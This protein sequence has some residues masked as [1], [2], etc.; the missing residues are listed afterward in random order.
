MRVGVLYR[1]FDS[2]RHLCLVPTEARRW[3]ALGL[4]LEMVVGRQ[5]GAGNQLWVLWKGVRCS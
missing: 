2:A 5:G 1:C 3:D 4:A